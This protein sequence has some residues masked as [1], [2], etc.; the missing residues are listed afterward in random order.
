MEKNKRWQITLILSVLLLTLYNILPTLFYYSKPLNAPVT[1]K[2]AIEIAQTAAS[3]VNQLEIESKDWV[4]AFSD[5]LKIK[6]KSVEISADLPQEI[7]VKFKTD[8]DAA[9]FKKYLPGAGQAIPFY[10]AKLSLANNLD[11]Q[12][13][14]TVILQRQIPIHF[15]KNLKGFQYSAL[16]KD[17]SIAPLN[18]EVVRDR[19]LSLSE[20]IGQESDNAKLLSSIINDKTS[21]RS[22]EYL[23]ILSSNILNYVNTLGETSPIT[24]R[25]F[26]SFTQGRFENRTVAI[27]TLISK[28][29]QLKEQVKI[30]KVALLEEEKTLAKEGNFLESSKKQQLEFLEEREFDL[31]RTTAVLRKHAKVFASGKAPMPLDALSEIIKNATQGATSTSLQSIIIGANNPLVE[32][33][34]IDWSSSKFKLSLHKDVEALIAKVSN[35][36]TASQRESV[37]QLIFNEIARISRESSENLVPSKDSFDI[38]FHTLTDTQSILVYDLKELAQAQ[39]KNI[40]TFLNSHWTPSSKE[41]DKENFPIVDQASYELLS[42]IEKKFCLLVSSPLVEKKESD[43]GFKNSSIYVVAK[44]LG[45]M[46]AKYSKEK[47][48]EASVL[49]FEELQKLG[50]ELQAL[51]FV[52]YPGTTY[53]LPEKYANDY[54]FEAENYYRPIL[55]ATKEK[56]SVH[57]TNRFAVLELSNQRQRILAVNAIET[58]DQENLLKWRDEYH[59]SLIDPALAS[60]F[61]VP[62]PTQNPLWSNLKLSTRKYFRGDERKILNWGLDLSGG[63]TVQIEL[64]DQ[65][66]K[67]VTNEDDLNQGVNELYNRVNKMGLSEV[68]IRKEGHNITLDFPG[69]QTLSAKELIKASTMSFHIVNE[70]FS[71]NNPMLKDA[72]ARFLQEIWNEAVVT[73]K[74]DVESINIIAFNHLY[75]GSIDA[76]SVSPRSEAAKALLKAGLSLVAPES[77]ERSAAFNDTTSKIAIMRGDSYQDWHY[78]TNPLMIVFNNYALEG[79]NLSNI[80]AGFDPSE[81]NFLSFEVKGSHTSRGGEKTNPSNDLYAWTSVFSKEKISGTPYEAF[82]QGQGWRMAMILNDEVVNAPQ[83]AGALKNSGRITGHFTQREIGKLEADLKAGSLTFTPYILSEKNV[84]PELGLK[85]RQSGIIATIVALTLVIGVMCFYY[86]FAGVIASIA[87]L[88]NLLIMWATLQNLGATITLAS[89]AGIILTM[90]MAVDA[91]V[92]IFERIREEFAITQRIHTAIQAGYKKAFAAILDS[93]I[94]TIIAGLVL[95]NFDS[96][97]VKGFALTLIIGIASSMFTALFLTRCFFR[98]WVQNREHTHLKMMNIIKGSRFDFLKFAKPALAAV[99]A[100]SLLGGFL[101]QKEKHTIFGMDFTGGFALNIEAQPQKADTNYRALV[102]SA[103]LKAGLSSREFEVRELSPSNHLRIFLAKSLELPGHP[104][105]NLAISEDILSS[106]AYESNPRIVWVV[107]ALSQEGIMLLESSLPKLESS[108]TS[109]SGQMSSSMQNNAIIGLAI[110]LLCILFYITLR[111]EFKYAISATLGLAADVVVTLG[112]VGILHAL[113]V[114]VQIDLNTIAALLTIIGYSL[115]DTIIVFDRIREDVKLMRKHSLSEIINHSLNITLS[116]TTMTSLTTLV[117]LIALIAFGGETIFGFSLVMAIGVVVGT[118]ST[119]FVASFLL[120]IFQKKEKK[121]NVSKTVL[122]V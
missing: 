113:G 18:M 107:N 22:L 68:A 35:S 34:D 17:G 71:P 7:V 85:E 62:A 66:G 73:G 96:G 110:A 49:F 115:N 87:V 99:A 86:R 28:F 120:L 90:G 119:F 116:R 79:S 108:W 57:G 82:S 51:G 83:L 95:L 74:K 78:Q 97:P 47:E 2:E 54:I 94:T 111:F 121:E 3:R 65:K 16:S 6:P 122:T 53:P 39:V 109:V 75:G 13:L 61:E 60:R 114:P 30:E 5:L 43:I 9:L 50:S 36:S 72:T 80:R 44:G 76:E 26:A 10:P 32:K 77:N 117:V 70:K 38:N 41:L 58:A 105:A 8:K 104:F 59:A 64:R 45:Q 81:G 37:D 14:K 106:Y 102:E 55:M 27:E 15:D 42:P 92:L 23:Q 52:A 88:V 93:N 101:L 100:I 89:I 24:E 98:H 12:D 67:V 4:Y 103:L 91:N 11:A 25:F 69:S 118:L 33:I 31:L 84:S 63:K 21:P 46:I 19:L 40:Q 56:F 20:V 29:D 112:L 1:E 48:S